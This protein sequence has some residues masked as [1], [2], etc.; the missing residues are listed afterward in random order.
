M[1]ERSSRASSSTHIDVEGVTWVDM[2]QNNP[3]AENLARR[4]CS[5]FLNVTT[6]SWMKRRTFEASQ[7]LEQEQALVTGQQIVS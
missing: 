6:P 1:R 7:A 5:P 3:P 4:K 2:T